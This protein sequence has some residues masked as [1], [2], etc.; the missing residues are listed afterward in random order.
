VRT[1][2]VYGT[3]SYVPD[4]MVRD[5][6]TYRLIA[7]ELGSV[8]RVVN[9]STGTVAQAID[10]DPYGA[11]VSDT[12]PGFQPF[13]YAGGQRDPD[14]GLVQF[15]ARDY[16]PTLGRWTS[17]DPIDFD[18]GDTNLYAYVAGDP[19]NG[20]DPSGLLFA[21]IKDFF[22]ATTEAAANATAYW[23]DLSVNSDSSIVRGL[24]TGAGLFTSLWSCGNATKTAL[25]VAGGGVAGTALV[26]AAIARQA[27]VDAARAITSRGMARLATG[28]D[29]TAVAR[30]AVEARNALK[31]AA[32]AKLPRA[33]SRWAERRNLGRYGNPIG[34]SYDQLVRAGKTAEQIVS[35]A[36][37]TSPVINRLLFVR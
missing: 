13:G 1:R 31:V 34:P 22:D 21:E 4:Y 12:Q 17:K 36:G 2:Y 23:A 20:V 29:A 16:D 14:T 24:A 8:R 18:G 27:Y 10:Y 26:R 25:A 6:V 33:L 7:D 30:E 5:G 35:S 28:E 9:T 32:R 11:T 19:V 37:R 3:R 15:G